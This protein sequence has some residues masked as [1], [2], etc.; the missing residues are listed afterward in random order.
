[1]LEIFLICLSIALFLA[2]LFLIRKV[3]SLRERIAG[4]KFE[5]GSQAVKYGQLTEQFIPF[6]ETFP[7]EPSSFR[8]IGKPI[9]GVAFTDDEIV[10]CEFKTG[11]SQLSQRQR[12][13]KQ[14]VEAKKVKWLE[15]AIR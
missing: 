9:D 12:G 15:F 5:K 7:F 14:L 3:L 13:I 11:V 8:F 1:M 4:L 10:F 6:T 2:L